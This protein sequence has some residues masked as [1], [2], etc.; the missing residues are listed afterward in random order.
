MARGDDYENDIL[1]LL[2]GLAGVFIFIN[3]AR[4]FGLAPG[5][6]FSPEAPAPDF[7]NMIGLPY[8]VSDAGRQAIKDQEKFSAYPYPDGNGQSVAWGHQIQ[9]GESFSY[10]MSFDQG[11]ALFSSDIAKVEGQINSTVTVPLNQNQVDA[12]GDF[13]YRIGAG[14][15][16]K[17][18]A[19]AQ[20]NQGNYSAAAQAFNNFIRTGGK[21]SADLQARAQSE[22]SMFSGAGA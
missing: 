15:W 21:I 6:S 14:N 11:E 2:A 5:L 10:P 18:Q 20:L 17:S 16:R 7:A 19:L 1:R 13:I 22:Q 12:L 3:L 4:S 8:T 9:P